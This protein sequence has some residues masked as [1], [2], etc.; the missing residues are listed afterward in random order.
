MERAGFQP[1]ANRETD[2]INV[3]FYTTGRRHLS[4]QHS[5]PKAGNVITLS[6]IFPQNPAVIQT[7]KAEEERRRRRKKKKK[8]EE[9]E[10]EQEN[11]S[12]SPML[13]CWRILIT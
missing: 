8:E 12:V 7:L 9:E 6:Y 1:H 2:L 4:S 10:E 13:A 3:M 5:L 11:E